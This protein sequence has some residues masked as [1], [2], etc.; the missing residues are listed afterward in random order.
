[1]VDGVRLDGVPAA[2][3]LQRDGARQAEGKF[4]VDGGAAPPAQNARLSMI[5]GIGLESMLALQAVDDAS[6]RDRLARK[7]GNAML[8]ALTGLQ[9]AALTGDD[10]STA[11]SALLEL[12]ENVAA[13]A[14]PGL[15][16]VLREVE[17]RAKVEIARRRGRGRD[18][19]T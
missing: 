8:V 13:A 16:A 5:A 12:T 9:K 19:V 11:L 10:P 1:M 4:V 14:D 3:A 7:R 18:L 17:L 2:A 6:E 15:D